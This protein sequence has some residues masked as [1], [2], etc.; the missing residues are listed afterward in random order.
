MSVPKVPAGPGWWWRDGSLVD[1]FMSH[2]AAVVEL[3]HASG[4]DPEGLYPVLNDGLWESEVLS[5]D[6]AAAL[7]RRAEEAESDADRLAADL[8][9]LQTAYDVATNRAERAE[10]VIAKARE[11]E[12]GARTLK[13]HWAQTASAPDRRAYVIDL[14]ALRAI[15][16]ES[17][18]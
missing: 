11:W 8:T 2:G 12:A 10:R 3:C 7:T 16:G 13:S 4:P 14:E 1:V 15:L 9:G 18:V 6:E 5:H 17:D